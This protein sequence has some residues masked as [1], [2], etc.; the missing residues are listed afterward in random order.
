[1]ALRFWSS[2][3]GDGLA[4]VGATPLS[5][6]RSEVARRALLIAMATVL[7]DL[8]A[9]VLAYWVSVSARHDRSEFPY[10]MAVL[11][12]I[13]VWPVVFYFSG[14]YSRKEI[15]EPSL[16]FGGILS[17][18]TMSA[19]LTI[20]VTYAFEN[21]P[22]RSW[23][24]YLWLVSLALVLAGRVA[25]LQLT[26]ALNRARWLGL[27]TLVIGSNGEARTLARVLRQR[28]HLGYDVV[29]YIGPRADIVD[30]LPSAPDID[31]LRRHVIDQDIAAIFIAGSEVGAEL[32]T[33]IDKELTGLN[34]RIRTSLG[35]PHLAA[36]R[37]LV[38]EV[39][40]MAML[41]LE[42]ERPAQVQLQMKRGL[43]VTLSVIGLL[44]GLPVLIAIAIAI[45]LTDGGPIIFSQ[46][47]VGAGG[48]P[49]TMHKFRTMVPN[50][51]K[52]RAEL[53]H[54][55][56]ADGALF[57]M[58]KDPRVTRVGVHLRKLG[59]DELPQL[60]N[61][62]IG[63]MSLVG[64]RPALPDEMA[65]WSPELATRLEAKPGLTGLWQVS[66]RHELAFEDY[67]RYDLFYVENWSFG[68]DLQIIA[69]TVPA[70]LS[71]AGAF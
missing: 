67:V 3:R 28:R 56:E 29:G 14:L 20:V 12:T 24:V 64:P 13:P 58:R 39:D 22:A 36:S 33:Q 48:E 25:M 6:R 35:V 18:A 57:K 7:V 41:A 47:R 34:I 16:R 52:L 53:V 55:N 44:L 31:D 43:D 69:R 71:R 42:R 21:H 62:L 65:S 5:P 40:G 9:V 2:P 30:G 63:E 26:Q 60:F 59:L 51:E 17:G 46:T 68:L 19:L 4:I 10:A 1:V 70:L 11:A 23:V 37:V 15:L 66:G 61:I 45:K 32:L 54:A 27:R 8:I 49:F 50:A 38:R